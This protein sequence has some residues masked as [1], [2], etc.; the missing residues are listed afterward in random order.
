M[1]NRGRDNSPVS[2]TIALCWTDW[3]DLH[4]L[5]NIRFRCRGRLGECERE[6][7]LALIDLVE[8]RLHDPFRACWTD[9]WQAARATMLDGKQ[10]IA[11]IANMII[12]API[13]SPTRERVPRPAM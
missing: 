10:Q 4:N 3:G 7:N 1:I 2:S 13:E 8:E 5:I 6:A 12:A 9:H 11:E